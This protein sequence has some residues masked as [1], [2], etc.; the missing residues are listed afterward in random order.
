M[1]LGAMSLAAQ[2]LK[3]WRRK[4]GLTQ[5]ECAESLGIATQQFTAY[6]CG[7]QTPGLERAVAFESLTNGAVAPRDW[8]TA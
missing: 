6:E 3:R 2:K 5:R 7:K 4:T 1:T 8:L